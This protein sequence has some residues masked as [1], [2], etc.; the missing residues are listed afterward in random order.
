MPQGSHLRK[1]G[2]TNHIKQWVQW[3]AKSF[4]RCDIKCNSQTWGLVF[5]VTEPLG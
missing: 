5:F 3:G 4:G 2:W 1:T